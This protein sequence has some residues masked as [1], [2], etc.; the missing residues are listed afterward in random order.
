[1]VENMNN[2]EVLDSEETQEFEVAEEETQTPVEEEQEE[3]AVNDVEDEKPKKDYTKLSRLAYKLLTLLT[4]I[5]AVVA[6]YGLV[7]KG[8]V[9]GEDFVFSAQGMLTYILDTI[10]LVSGENSQY[11][12]VDII[13]PMVLV[14]WY[15]VFYV[16]YA[17]ILVINLIILVFQFLGMIF[18]RKEMK[19]KYSKFSKRGLTFSCLSMAFI[20]VCLMFPNARLTSE[21]I[22]VLVL[23]AVIYLT[24]N[25]VVLL[26]NQLESDEKNWTDFGFDLGRAVAV[27][28]VIALF[29]VAFGKF[30]VLDMVKYVWYIDAKIDIYSNGILMGVLVLELWL[31]TKACKLGRISLKHYALDNGKKPVNKLIRKKSITLLV[32]SILILGIKLFATGALATGDYLNSIMA[33][34]DTYLV[35]ILGA[36]TLLFC[37]KTNKKEPEEEVRA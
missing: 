21:G 33:Y 4:F 12:S 20:A 35:F 7:I 25:A 28:G 26:F 27:L 31:V 10:T 11:G 16:I 36:I 5:S 8:L 1:M 3:N 37:L 14:I 13:L 32:L 30:N 23:A 24:T 15:A 6:L 19:L 2:Q 34:K 22:L 17:I 29:F 18:A 9:V